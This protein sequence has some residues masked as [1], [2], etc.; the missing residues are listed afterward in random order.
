MNTF[1]KDL[2]KIYEQVYRVN[3]SLSIRESREFMRGFNDGIN[4][5]WGDF[6]KKVSKG[7][8]SVVK[9]GQDA[10]NRGKEAISGAYDKGKELA[11]RAW[12]TVKDFS[13]S[14][15]NTISTA[16][17]SSIEYI[18]TA[19]GKAKKALE[20]MFFNVGKDLK[21]AYDSLKDKAQELQ[22]AISTIWD[23]IL[24]SAKDNVE[25]MKTK[26][27]DAKNWITTNYKQLES[28]FN[29]A[30]KSTNAV[31]KQVGADSLLILKKIGSGTVKAAGFLGLMILGLTIV[32]IEGVVKGVKAVAG[33]VADAAG[34]V[35]TGAANA[36]TSVANAATTL[37][38]EGEKALNAG[39]TKVQQ[40]WN[41]TKENAT[42]GW[43]EGKSMLPTKENFRYIKKFEGFT[44]TL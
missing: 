22:Q 1:I 21:K 32:S 15:Y 24:Q 17:T 27:A 43:A 36:A 38:D 6:V 18:A 11:K 39:L 37:G 7:V 34:A 42:A 41:T 10:V 31:I 4:E 28:D 16:Y 26:I 33:G 25:K 12:T 2:N 40:F 3:E 23:N 19:P 44:D 20:D 14:I 30:Q 13:Q 29:S 35:A 9:T 8:S 5:G